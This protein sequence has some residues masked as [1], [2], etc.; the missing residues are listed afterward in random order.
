MSGGDHGSYGGD[1]SDDDEPGY[2]DSAGY[3]DTDD[4]DDYQDFIDREF[5]QGA[6]GSRLTPLQYWTTIVLLLAF[7]FPI[8]WYLFWAVS[9]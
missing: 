4:D 7:T 8:L 2:D 1:V 6:G 9:Q 5:G 3:D